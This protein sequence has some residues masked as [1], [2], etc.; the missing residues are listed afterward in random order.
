M[1]PPHLQLACSSLFDQL[2]PGEDV[3]ALRHYE[4]LGG[5]DEIVRDYLDRVLETELPT[6]A[7]RDRAPRAARARRQRSRARR[8]HRRRARR[9][10]AGG[11]ARAGAR[12]CCACAASI[13]PLRAANGQ[14]A[15]ELVHDS[16]VPRVL[17]WS[18]RQD[19]ARQRA[20]EIV[21]HHLRGSR[22]ERPSL[23][24]AGELR[25]VQAVTPPRSRSS[26]VI[27]PQAA[28]PVVDAG[29]ARRAIAARAARTLDR[30]RRECRGRTRRR[31]LSRCALV[32]TNAKSDGTR[33]CSER[34]TS[35][36]SSSSCACSIG[37]HSDRLPSLCV[38]VSYPILHGVCFEPDPRMSSGPAPIL[39][40]SSARRS[41]RGIRARGDGA[42]KLA[43][44][45]QSWRSPDAVGPDALAAL[46]RPVGSIARIRIERVR[47]DLSV[48]V[49]TCDATALDTIVM[50]PGPYRTGGLGDPPLTVEGGLT[51][52][53]VLPE[54]DVDVGRFAIDRTEV[55]N[56][57]YRM[58]TA[59]RTSSALQLPA[60]PVRRNSADDYPV[61]ALSWPEARA[62]CRFIGKDLPTDSQWEKAFAGGSSSTVGRIRDRD[63]RYRGAPT[64][65]PSRTFA[66]LVES[67]LESVEANPETSAHMEC[68]T[69]Q[70]TS[71]SGPE[72]KCNPASM[73][74]AVAAGASVRRQ[75]W[76]TLAPSRTSENRRSSST[77]WGFDVWSK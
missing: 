28:R 13:V 74:R 10:R 47:S 4:Q 2:A 70:E 41:S 75:T 60:Y 51:A 25:E 64:T 35:E 14:P 24:T 57:A 40:P 29:E 11:R 58:A 37:I 42:S 39:S 61:A 18:D 8:P 65:R 5:L 68:A 67:N 1:Y 30:T 73:R 9:A 31:R 52:A 56:G 62:Y 20:L 26:I 46:A 33:S 72:P 69:S 32:P 48:D 49:P 71:R 77:S 15:W 19:L 44:E 27:L 63:V 6:R 34:P 16:L 17:A 7:R 12:G 53:D 43:V 23:L 22:A 54:K 45:R 76:W 3:L 36:P 55:T 50:P 38:C 59:P 66:I 21:R